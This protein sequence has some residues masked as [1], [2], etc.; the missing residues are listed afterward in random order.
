MLPND[1]S[2]LE[3]IS[4]AWKPF[5]CISDSNKL[6]CLQVKILNQ[7]ALLSEKMARGLLHLLTKRGQVAHLTVSM[8]SQVPQGIRL[9]ATSTE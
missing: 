8:E 6:I 2:N 9:S 4:I 5:D 1:A 3:E 7:W